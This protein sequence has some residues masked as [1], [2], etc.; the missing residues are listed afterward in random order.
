MALSACSTNEHIR[1][2]EPIPLLCPTDQLCQK[3]TITLK[4]NGDLVVALDKTL[5]EIEKCMLINQALTQC[6][7][8]YNRTLQ[9]KKYD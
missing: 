6:I 5:N 9:E 8:N 1:L 4:N 3:P 2:I 7:E